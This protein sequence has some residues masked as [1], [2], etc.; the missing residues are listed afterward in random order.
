MIWRDIYL[1][2]V[3]SVLDMNHNYMVHK[4]FY[5]IKYRTPIFMAMLNVQMCEQYSH[6]LNSTV[7]CKSNKEQTQVRIF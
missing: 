4:I 7:D 5:F 3:K 2:N 6:Q 1:W